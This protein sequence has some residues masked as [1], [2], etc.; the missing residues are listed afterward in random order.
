MEN[1]IRIQMIL[2]SDKK[3]VQNKEYQYL[4]TIENFKSQSSRL[5]DVKILHKE[6]ILNFI[7]KELN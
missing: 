4:V 7:N 6:E 2:G 5:E 3:P 1:I